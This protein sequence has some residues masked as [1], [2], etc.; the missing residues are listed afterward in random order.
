LVDFSNFF[1]G[2]VVQGAN[3]QFPYIRRDLLLNYKKMRE[4]ILNEPT[5][6]TNHP[7]SPVGNPDGTA[8]YNPENISD[9][10]E[11][12][13]NAFIRFDFGTERNDRG[14]SIDGNIGVR[15]VK[16]DLSSAGFYAYQAFDTDQ[17]EAET[18]PDLV[19]TPDA[20]D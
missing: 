9:I 8:N 2:G 5:L 18:Q 19:R 14:M 4:F 17:L 1:R 3:T 13:K 6:G 16:T 10:T 7:W 12:T 20:E 11:T 15:Y